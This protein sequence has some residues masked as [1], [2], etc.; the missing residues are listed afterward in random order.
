[1]RLVHAIHDFLPRHCA[2]SE[3]YAFELCRQLAQR[4]LVTVVCAEYDP[5]RA[6]G[7]VT[8][9][10]HDGLPV[11]E[12]VNNW[13]AND[14]ADGYQSAV[15]NEALGHVLRATDPEVLHIHNL[16]NLSFDLPQLARS[17]GIRTV[18]TLHDYT[19]VCPS[20][21]QRVHAAEEHVC[22]EID[23]DRCARCFPESPFFSQMA[24]ARIPAVATS[25]RMVKLADVMRRRLPV[26]FGQVER[27]I[28]RSPGLTVTRDDIQKRLDRARDVFDATDLFVA[29][30]EAL[31]AEYCRLGLPAAKLTVAD[32]G[33]TRIERTP[34]QRGNTLRLG[35]VGTLVWHKGVH[36]LI[37]AVRRLPAGRAEL[38]VFGDLNVFPNYVYKL[39]ASAKGL[40]VEF[41]GGFDASQKA[42]IY[43]R[44]DV[45][46]VPSLWPENSPLVIHEAFMAGVPVV[47]ARQGGIPGLIT[48]GVNGLLYDAF[49]ADDLARTLQRLI[50]EPGLV[51]RFASQL[52][53]V[54]SIEQDAMEWED[55]YEELVRV[56]RA[57]RVS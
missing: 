54:K 19:L 25:R 46:V 12:I 32:Y 53:A 40:P 21:G 2:G 45:L 27:Q 20:G 29:P 35:F 38:V 13:K 36:V 49:S 15:M 11:V 57:S 18:A 52:P 30:S 6:H 51:D 17:R 50:V 37:D 26:V 1:M 41:M 42:D 3:L 55:R 44:F 24:A 23:V 33:F 7:S 43:N 34:R 48:D 9:R 39:K 5:A 56:A 31:G 8:W 10:V 47:G 16:L 28:K 22:A 14:F 4:H